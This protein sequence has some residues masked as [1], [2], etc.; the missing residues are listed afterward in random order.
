MPDLVGTVDLQIGLPDLLNLH[1][2]GVISLGT[3]TAQFGLALA[4]RM[5]AVA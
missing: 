5:V 2:Q 4:G 1:H 3:G